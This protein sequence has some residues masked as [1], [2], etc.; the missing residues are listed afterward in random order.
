MPRWIASCRSCD[1]FDLLIA[2]QTGSLI[3]AI[4]LWK[5]SH[6]IPA[7]IVVVVTLCFAFLLHLPFENIER[8]ARARIRRRECVYCGELAFD[9]TG[10][11]CHNCVG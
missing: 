8:F 7:L 3:A 10:G 2:L 5:L 4:A 6:I 1:G 11:N 9:E